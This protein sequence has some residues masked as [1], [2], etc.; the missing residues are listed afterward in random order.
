MKAKLLC[1][2][3]ACVTRKDLIAGVM[4]LLAPPPSTNAQT[5]RIAVRRV[6]AMLVVGSSPSF[7]I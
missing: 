6:D 4:T 7:R 2:R 5:M 3:S 1:W